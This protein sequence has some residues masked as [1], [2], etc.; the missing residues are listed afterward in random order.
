M[1][2]RVRLSDEEIEIIREALR[3]YLRKIEGEINWEK[4]KASELRDWEKIK[5][6]TMRFIDWGLDKPF[7]SKFYPRRRR[8]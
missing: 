2:H 4:A 6:V 3:T 8:G 5:R 7:G 1:V